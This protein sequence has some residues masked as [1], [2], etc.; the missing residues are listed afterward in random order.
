MKNGA[1]HL[2][3]ALMLTAAVLPSQAAEDENRLS[4]KVVHPQVENFPKR[5]RLLLEL[6]ERFLSPGPLREGWRIPTGATWHPA[7]WVFGTLR[8]GV[9]GVKT[10]AQTSEWANRLDIY[11]NLRISGTE[12]IVVGFRPLNEFSG[13]GYHF[14][15]SNNPATPNGWRNKFSGRLT[16]LFFEG[17]IGEIFPGWDNDDRHALDI[18]F[19]VGRQDLV[20][21]DG[22]LINDNMDAVGLTRNSLMPW[23]LTNLRVTGLYAWNNIHRH[24]LLE[25]NSA[26]FF[27]LFT[28]ADSRSTTVSIDM[29]YMMA[30]A[31]TGDAFYAGV[32]AIQHIGPLNTVF[33]VNASIPVKGDTPA[34]GRGALVYSEWSWVKPHSNNLVYFTN[35]WAI[36]RY[37]TATRDPGS[38]G[39]LYRAGILFT[40][41]P[42]GRYGAALSSQTTDVVGGSLAYQM[43]FARDRKQLIFEAGGRKDTNGINAGAAAIG[44]RYQN[45]VGRRMVVQLDGFASVRQTGPATYGGRFEI[46]TKF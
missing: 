34:T 45:A 41:A 19:S 11:G 23:G 6:G 32:S 31:A 17:E 38:P 42:M 18:G 4:D 14:R 13:V 26:H 30:K 44:M 35:F 3:F 27:G 40:P 33:R 8:T 9:Q 25:D 22:M 20:F 39:P 24:D 12:R 1:T 29:A 28:E 2:F 46:L 5:P 15:P 10:G 16:T 36:R 43:T 7:L 21:Q 37:S